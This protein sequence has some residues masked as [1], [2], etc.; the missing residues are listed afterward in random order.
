MFILKIRAIVKY[1]FKAKFYSIKLSLATVH[2]LYFSNAT[3]FQNI[4]PQAV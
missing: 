4:V 2:I 3:I 1:V